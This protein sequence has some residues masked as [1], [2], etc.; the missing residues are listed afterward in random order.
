MLSTAVSSLS[1]G[2]KDMKG[3]PN[4]RARRD[5]PRV[6]MHAAESSL[7]GKSHLDLTSRDIAMVAGTHAGMVNY[8]FNSK[9]CLLAAL[10]ENARDITNRR[11]KKIEEDLDNGIGD[12]TE[13]LVRG[14][15]ESYHPHS[16][17]SS[18]IFIE[19]FRPDSP[20]AQSY[21][22]YSKRNESVFVRLNGLL[23]KLVSKGVYRHDL[24]TD[25]AV[26]MLM[27]L[28]I[29]PLILAQVWRVGGTPS[30]PICSEDWFEHVVR[31]MRREASCV[32]SESSVNP[33]TANAR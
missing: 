8:Y 26:W 10:V 22:D 1:S 2:D 15:L 14:L 3:R 20:I 4:G 33:P 24:D 19:I 31:Y 13:T 9:D 11:L 17:I 18:I 16:A 6:L 28:I 12:A 25:A 5:L 21:R 30:E 29:G 27:S 23:Q 32:V 7:H